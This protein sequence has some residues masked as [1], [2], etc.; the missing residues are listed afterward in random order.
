[1]K[2]ILYP[3]II[4]LIA[5]CGGDKEVTIESVI[6]T[7]DIKAI[8]AK[9]EELT[10]QYQELAEKIDK[11]GNAID[12]LGGA[13]KIPLVTSYTIKDTIFN[14]YFEVQGNIQTKE[15]LVLTPEYSGVLTQILVKEGQFVKKGQALAKIDDGGL[16]QQLAQLQVQAQ[17]AKTTFERQERLWNQKIGSEIQYLQA[18]TNYEAQ[19]KAIKQLESSLSKTVIK[20]PFSGTIDEI[21]TEKGNVVA[22]GA[23][24]IVRI[25]SL[26]NMYVESQIPEK[27]VNKVKKGTNVSINIPTIGEKLKAKVSQTSNFIDP[28]SRTYRVEVKIPNKDKN[29]KPNLNSK[30]QI[31]DYV[32]E[33]AILIPQSLISENAEGTQS[34]YTVEKNAKN[35]TVAKQHAIKTGKTQ[36]SLVEVLEGVKVG[37][38]IIEEGARSVRNNQEVKIIK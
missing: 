18:K 1:M 7:K 25:V 19:E 27:Y 24:P 31:T 15:N 16:S 22:P 20:A 13:K 29:L 9:K 26:N 34:V 8:R 33:K 14:H 5:S 35:Q 21:I 12:S 3:L 28:S 4:L 11:L 10:T 38:L 23:T 32:N 36:N 17:L 30:L 37:D 6:Q 2:N